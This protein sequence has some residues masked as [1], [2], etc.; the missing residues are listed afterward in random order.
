MSSGALQP[1]SSGEEQWRDIRNGDRTWLDDE[2]T[3]YHSWDSICHIYLWK[4][5]YV[6]FQPSFIK[7]AENLPSILEFP[8]LRL[9]DQGVQ[10]KLVTPPT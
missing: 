6:W 4:S 8:T 2:F 10:S 7:L 1:H 5:K 9:G 3:P